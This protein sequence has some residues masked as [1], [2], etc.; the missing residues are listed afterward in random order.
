MRPTK[1]SVGHV[2]VSAT[3]ATTLS[4][5]TKVS[6]TAVCPM[7][8]MELADQLCRFPMCV[9]YRSVKVAATGVAVVMGPICERIR[10]RQ[11][12]Q[13]AADPPA[14]GESQECAP[15]LLDVLEVLTLRRH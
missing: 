15:E 10:L 5:L 14:V 6:D 4:N 9:C 2:R 7:A 11:V 13:Q 3:S 12:A 8:Q 1:G